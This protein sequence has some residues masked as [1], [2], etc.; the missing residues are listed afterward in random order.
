M[1]RRSFKRHDL[2]LN[3]ELSW[4]AFDERVLGEA[5]NPA[6]PLL[7]R[8]K[9]L[10]ISCSNLDEF[11]EVRVAGVAQQ[12]VHGLNVKAPD[13]LAPSEV[14]D[15]I[16]V[17][18]HRIVQRQYDLLN[19]DLLPALERENIRFIRRSQLLPE[20]RRWAAR[21]FHEEVYPVLTPV[22]ID[23]SHPFPQVLN[24]SLNFIVTL[25]GTD[26]FGREVELA[27]VQA[28]RIL[29]RI[30]RL[31]DVRDGDN[32]VFLSAIIH[33]YVDELFPGLK[34]TGCYQFRVT[35]NSNLFIDEEEV[36]N[37]LKALEGE[38]RYRHRGDAIRLEVADNCPEEVSERLRVQ[39]E[40]DPEDVYRVNGPVNLYRM[41]DVM[42]M[43]KRPDL[44]DAPH[45]PVLPPRF[46]E[47]EAEGKSIFDVLRGGDVLLHHPFESFSPVT[48]LLRQAAEDPQ[49]LAIRMTLYRTSTDSALLKSLI[50]AAESGKQVAVVVEIKARFDEERNIAWARRLEDAGAQVVYGIVGFKTHA[51]MLLVVR[52]E[53]GGLKFYGHLGTGNY[54]PSTANLY[55]DLG[56]LTTDPVLTNEMLELF[57]ILT[58]AG[59]YPPFKK[60]V[61]A[62]V[63]LHKKMMALI[64][65]ERKRALAGGEAWM[66]LKMNALTE[67]KV[68]EALYKA[69]N[70]GVKI[71]LI[72]RGVCCL[73]PGVPGV[74]E[75]IEVRSVIGRFLE[76]TRIFVFGNGGDPLIYCGSAD[77]MDR[78]FFRRIETV[79][80]IENPAFKKRI[81]EEILG[82]YLADTQ[83]SW[84]LDGGG[85]YHQVVPAE[86]EKT[87]SA[88]ARLMKL[89]EEGKKV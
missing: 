75:N 3:R 81:L 68:I 30:L 65:A 47:A 66:L 5:T 82:S 89:G 78:N 17:R 1:H 63:G 61:V 54:H 70:A 46:V 18:C 85:Q 48:E 15:E 43:V 36:E 11:F 22:V 84:R 28:P 13:G 9:F 49:V 72:V 76:H 25:E 64:D 86:G 44:R 80:P 26:H 59:R 51:K 69:S 53:Q 60:L 2:Y 24:K 52:K 31:P 32:F 45:R 67:P 40:L 12:T 41:M 8:L 77:W 27:I 42:G 57:M 56:L 79:F 10:A 55:T 33:A 38:L 19:D 58:G 23:P 14:L 62:P 7:E 88:F 83:Q 71:T 29:P 37:L 35:R 87:V 6:N 50:K 74:S 34:V 20:E 4:L 21:Y 39:F 73:R 16:E